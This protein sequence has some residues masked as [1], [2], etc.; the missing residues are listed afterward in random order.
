M[1]CIITHESFRESFK[2][3]EVFEVAEKLHGNTGSDNE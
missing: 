2:L 1:E 3:G